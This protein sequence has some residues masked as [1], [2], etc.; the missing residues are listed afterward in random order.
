MKYLKQFGGKL[1]KERI[2]QYEKSPNWK[3][4][5]F[6]NLVQT[7]IDIGGRKLQG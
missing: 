7:G 5:A 1:T 4:G 2:A 3:D 6:R